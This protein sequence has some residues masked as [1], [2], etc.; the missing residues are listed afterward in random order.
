MTLPASGAISLSQVNVE[1]GNSSIAPISLN[2]STVRTLF[3][4]PS[5]AISMNAGHGKSNYLIGYVS[6]Y[7]FAN[8]VSYGVFSLYVSGA[9]PYS[10]IGIQ[11]YANTSGQPLGGFIALGN[12][13]GSGNFSY[14]PVIS[15]TDPYWYPPPQTNWF[16]VF[17]DVSNV[18]GA[19]AAS[20]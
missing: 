11:F 3:G 12:C 1:L 20:S 14:T 4:I 7:G 15:N 5:G 9:Q 18:L 17:Q 6:Y 13:D 8:Y 2:Q 19:F 16:E 10:A